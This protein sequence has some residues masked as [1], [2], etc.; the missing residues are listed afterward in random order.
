MEIK[1]NQNNVN[2]ILNIFLKQNVKNNKLNEIVSWSLTGGKRLRSMIV[3]DITNSVNNMKGLN[4]NNNKLAISCEFLHTASLVIDDLPCMDN[5]NYRRDIKTIHYKYGVDN[6]YLVSG[7]LISQVLKLINENIDDIKSKFSEDYVNEIKE[8]ILNNYLINYN[9][10]ILGQYVDI[11]PLKVASEQNISFVGQ[12]KE[13]YLRKIILD[14]TAPFFEISFVSSYLL[15]GGTLQNY[16]EIREI[17][18]LFGI[19]FQISD[20]FEDQKQDINKSCKSLVQNYVIVIGKEKA[21]RDF[22][23]LKNIL[24]MKMKKLQLYSKLF[25]EILNYLTERV[26]TYK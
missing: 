10:A 7:F 12:I 22:E 16:E 9:I 18:Q 2:N 26:E 13:E 25:I 11:Y 4:I 20:D 21:F 15:S 6:A 5:D 14:K 19:I 3:L 24:I 8:K 1:K 17:S 23:K